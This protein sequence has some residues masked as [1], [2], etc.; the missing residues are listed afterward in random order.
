MRTQT[1]IAGPVGGEAF[2][3]QDGGPVVA[4]AESGRGAA[5][6]RS[7]YLPGPVPSP[8]GPG[9]CRRGSQRGARGSPRRSRRA[10]GRA[11]PGAAAGW[12]RGRRGRART[13]R[14]VPEWE[15]PGPVSRPPPPRPSRGTGLPP[16][17]RSG[18]LC[19]PE[20]AFSQPGALRVRDAGSGAR[21]DGVMP[22]PGGGG[23]TRGWV[24]GDGVGPPRPEQRCGPGP[25]PGPVP[26]RA[27]CGERRGRGR[28]TGGPGSV[29]R[30]PREGGVRGGGV[31]VRGWVLPGGA[32]AATCLRLAPKKP[33]RGEGQASQ[34]QVEGGPDASVV[35][36]G[37][38]ENG[39]SSNKQSDPFSPPSRNPPQF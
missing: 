14:I 30:P 27:G 29:V 6:C 39:L 37:M 38:L 32:G 35:S 3:F 34:S 23:G 17:S 12:F 21:S 16:S 28:G 20:A 24:C 19:K 10:G 11:A 26:P 5:P 8:S 7:W 18:S 25:G 2:D 1:A 31:G 13:G 4:G 15:P 9:G 22:G 33:R 36:T